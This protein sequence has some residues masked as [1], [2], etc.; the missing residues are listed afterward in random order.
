VA[1]TDSAVLQRF[2]ENLKRERERK[3]LS[4]DVLAAKAG[5]SRTVPGLLEHAER[6]VK[7][8]TVVRL[9]QALDIPAGRLLDGL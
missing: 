4:Q 8:G 7:I 5:L 2:A 3:G 9:A 6:E 1:Q